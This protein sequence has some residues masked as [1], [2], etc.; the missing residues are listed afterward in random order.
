MRSERSDAHFLIAKPVSR[1]ADRIAL[2]FTQ[3]VLIMRAVCSRG[4]EASQQGSD[5]KSTRVHG[6]ISAQVAP[7]FARNTLSDPKR[8][9]LPR[10]TGT[11]KQ[12]RVAMLHAVDFALFFNG[13]PHD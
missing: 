8:I 5:Y 7:Y 4:A 1:G 12:V 2:R 3:C 6:I 11:T 9:A 10:E 13:K